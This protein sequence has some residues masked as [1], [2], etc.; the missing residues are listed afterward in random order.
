MHHLR[1]SG[2]SSPLTEL[3]N[4]RKL[5]SIG[6]SCSPLHERYTES[7][8]FRNQRTFVFLGL[9]FLLL[10]S[11]CFFPVLLCLVCIGISSQSEEAISSDTVVTLMCAVS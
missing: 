6:M 8:G 7:L 4:Q 5:L 1:H 10:V 3:G 2:E 11:M 9:V